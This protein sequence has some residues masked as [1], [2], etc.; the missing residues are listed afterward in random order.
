MVQHMVERHVRLFG[1]YHSPHPGP[2]EAR[3]L[4]AARFV[5]PHAFGAERIEAENC[6]QSKREQQEKMAMQSAVLCS[7]HFHFSTVIVVASWPSWSW[8]IPLGEPDTSPPS[9]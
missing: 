4:Y 1:G 3:Q 7:E 5:Q 9:Q 8:Q 6:R 2:I